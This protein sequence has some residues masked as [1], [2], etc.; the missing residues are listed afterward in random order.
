[1]SI[2]A[3]DLDGTIFKGQT[4]IDGVKE[5]L[6]KIINAGIEIY[7]T[8]N[9]SSQTPSEIKDKLEYLL[10]LNIDISKIITPLVIFQNLYSNNK[11][12]IFIYGS[13]NLKNYIKNLNINVTSLENAE[14]VLIGR[15]EEN[16]F[17]EINEIIKN[18][19]L[20]KNILSLNKDL[21]FPTEFGEKAGNGAVV[22]IIEDKL[23]IN[24]PTLGKSGDHYSSYFIQN[25]ITVN[26]VIGDRVDT[27]I[28]FGKNLNA[29]T[30][31]VSSG[32]KNY[33]DVNIADIQLNKF[34]DV[35][36]FLT[37]QS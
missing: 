21:T 18:V 24:I 16:N 30:F 26:Y 17:S 6:L 11:S 23:S 10:Q 25:K 33:L 2:I 19:S 5:G 9:N 22:K 1:M 28:I 32:I 29:K 27:D 12:N 36:P 31:L 7:Y 14:L 3:T 4:L 13:D 37:E 20:G 15:K 8:T 35:V 34:S